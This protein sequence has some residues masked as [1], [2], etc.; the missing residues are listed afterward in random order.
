MSGPS[1]AAD[2]AKSAAMKT[3]PAAKTADAT[4][5]ASAAKTAD[6]S[7]GTSGDAAATTK[8]A[9]TDTNSDVSDKTSEGEATEKKSAPPKSKTASD[10]HGGTGGHF[11]VQAM[12]EASSGPVRS[13]LLL[14]LLML[15]VCIG[16]A[17]ERLITLKTSK[18][19]SDALAIVISDAMQ[20]D[21]I[22]EALKLSKSDKF[23][24]SHLSRL[25]TS[26]L[27]EFSA[28]PD[29]YGIES[30]ERALEKNAVGEGQALNKGLNI[31]ATTGAT[32]PFVG[33][34]GTIFGIINAFSMIGTAG[35]G[36]LMT[37]APAI[38]EA[39]ITTAF[40]IMVAL[41]GVWLF[42]YFTGVIERINNDM[43]M[44][45]QE[46]ID[47]CHKRI[48]PPFNEDAAK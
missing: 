43:A 14:L 36:D 2:T 39:L 37:L 3:V 27:H 28:R 1:K 25:L 10:D 45:G 46:L 42:N 48:A 38:G 17:I 6:A 31:L 24:K 29:S 9:A 18:S 44:N 22:Q 20:N 12:W 35:G 13:V 7:K 33:L 5:A 47:W 21:N 30:V 41:V 15:F 23:V 40:G 32:A 26:G 4:K 8:Q 34:V 11:T 16:V 19:Q